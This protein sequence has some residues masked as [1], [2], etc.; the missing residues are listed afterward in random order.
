ML[1][2]CSE[3]STS[4]DSLTAHLKSTRGSFASR[5]RRKP[6]PRRG[7]GK[8]GG[9]AKQQ[10]PSQKRQELALRRIRS[11]KMNQAKAKVLQ[12]R[13][14]KLVQNRSLVIR[15]D[16]AE[17][18]PSSRELYTSAT[19][20]GTW[21]TRFSSHTSPSLH[22]STAYN[23]AALYRTSSEPYG[24]TSSGVG[25]DL[26]YNPVSGMGS[27][28]ISGSQVMSPPEG[29]LRPLIQH[30]ASGL[31]R[32]ELFLSPVSHRP[33][34]AFDKHTL[35][36]SSFASDDDASVLLSGRAYSYDASDDPPSGFLFSRPASEP[37]PFDTR[38][39]SRPS[40]ATDRPI[41]RSN[42]NDLFSEQLTVGLPPV[43]KRPPLVTTRS[44]RGRKRKVRINRL[45]PQANKKINKARPFTTV[46][47]QPHGSHS[48]SAS[49]DVT[50]ARTDLDQAVSSVATHIQQTLS[51][52]S[53]QPTTAVNPS[54]PAS[55]DVNPHFANARVAQLLA[56]IN[57]GISSFIA[58][59]KQ[60][61]DSLD[62][63]KNLL[64]E[65]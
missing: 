6:H 24:T 59:S 49:M 38:S 12:A 48:A 39:A 10:Q 44:W 28:L 37:L 62:S 14:V 60:I 1:D 33:E 45:A 5:G 32:D 18:L 50:A 27:A 7:K 8:R 65:R 31:T 61:T 46:H 29:D 11:L 26:N 16:P 43:A 58:A 23:T 4:V 36:F 56:N 34:K 47:P 13:E 52:P 63:L 9:V 42:P 41:P 64:S 22:T 53:L 51:H 20:H 40:S 55:S 57:A 30:S 3:Q 54:D 2:S 21:P 15:G 19:Q 25:R 35:P 17:T